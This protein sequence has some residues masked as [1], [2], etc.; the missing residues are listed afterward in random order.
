MQVAMLHNKKKFGFLHQK[1]TKRR[2]AIVHKQMKENASCRS[3]MRNL[4][5]LGQ[6]LAS[7]DTVLQG[8]AL[9]EDEATLMSMP[10]NNVE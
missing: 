1:L 8:F 2:M 4:K 5:T 9:M 3:I 7:I 6:S 10:G